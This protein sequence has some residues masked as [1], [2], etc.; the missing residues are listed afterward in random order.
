MGAPPGY[1]VSMRARAI[2][3]AAVVVAVGCEAGVRSLSPT[4]KPAAT[5]PEPDGGPNGDGGLVDAAGPD[6]EPVPT[7]AGE[8]DLD[9]AFAADAAVDDTGFSLCPS[10][11]RPAVTTG[12]WEGSTA[13]GYECVV[14]PDGVVDSQGRMI[15][16][17][18]E[19][20]TA[21]LHVRRWDGTAWHELGVPVGEEGLSSVDS[22]A[23][24]SIAVDALNRP[25]VAWDARTGL[26]SQVF[27]HRYD[28]TEWVQSPSPAASNAARTYPEITVDGR[29]RA[30]VS[31]TSGSGA[32][33]HNSSRHVAVVHRFVFR[34]HVFFADN[35][36]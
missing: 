5:V 33:A 14:N 8:R 10:P 7:D 23:F 15:I 36:L 26:G 27:V 2:L 35:F 11:P 28:G 18:T 16:V 1:D 24:V 32:D 12:A 17:W 25:Y 30:V 20:T 3:G 21:N 19:C 6:A 29:G 22:H 13:L 9:A 34:H 31:W 4:M